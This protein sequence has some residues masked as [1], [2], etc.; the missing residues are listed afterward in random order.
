M[1]TSG[2]PTKWRALSDAIVELT[3]VYRVTA[4]HR[5]SVI[6][7]SARVKT[8]SRL[9]LGH[10]VS[11]QSGS[12]LHCGGKAW[13]GYAGFIRLGNGVSIGPYCIL[14][15]AGGIALDDYVHLGP[16]V[17]LMSQAGR[18]DAKRLGPHPTYNLAPIRIGTGSW[19]G[20]GA[21][22]L[23]GATLGCCVNVG[24]NSVVAGD[25]PDYAVV[26]GNPAR[27]VMKNE[28]LK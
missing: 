19:I 13:A 16:G 28:A 17:M 1:L 26:V 11:V 12:I 9:L 5:R 6:A 8:P 15:G 2:K 18:H 22:I 23:G 3:G 24:P 27:V 20:S 14:Y 7:L 10:H 21:T 25:V 4:W